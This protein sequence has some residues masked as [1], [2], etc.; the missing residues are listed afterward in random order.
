MLKWLYHRLCPDFLSFLLFTWACHIFPLMWLLCLDHSRLNVH[1]L[2]SKMFCHVFLLWS[3]TRSLSIV[4]S[5]ISIPIGNFEIFHLFEQL[6]CPAVYFRHMVF[7]HHPCK[8]CFWNLFD[9]S[10]VSRRNS[11]NIKVHSF[12]RRN[13]Q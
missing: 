5:W 3:L 1:F 7:Y 9:V 2:T 8:I 4:P 12:S 6:W 11:L 13:F 10:S